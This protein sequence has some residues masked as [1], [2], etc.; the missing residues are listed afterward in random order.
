M[1]SRVRIDDADVGI[2]DLV[3]SLTTDSR[4]LIGDEVRLAR[5]EARESLRSGARGA[6]WLAVAFGAVVIALTAFT[7]LLTVAVGRLTGNMW[8]GALITGALEVVA[9][10]LALGRGVALYRE[11]GSYTLGETRAEV[12]RTTRWAR[13]QMSS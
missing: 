7:V 4:R 5:L 9:G 3:R 13:R 6:L 12:A 1:T 11:P 2:P 8:A 10:A